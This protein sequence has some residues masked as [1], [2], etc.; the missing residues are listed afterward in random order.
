MIK[1]NLTTS[2]K[3]HELIKEFLE[4]NASETLANKIN[5]GV[6]IEKEGKTLE[7][8]FGGNGDLYWIIDNIK[9]KAKVIKEF[10]KHLESTYQEKFIIT[11]E[12]YFI[13][14]LFEELI[15]DIENS[16]IYLSISNELELEFDGFD[17]KNYES[18][19]ERCNRLNQN[20]KDYFRYKLLC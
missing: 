12:N 19:K 20:H 6:L 13:Y 17:E 9:I 7:I 8:L 1:L 2:C 4:Q 18:S 15:N 16:R 3:E 5:N 11:K 10:K 14:Q